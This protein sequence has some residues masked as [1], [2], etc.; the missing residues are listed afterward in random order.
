MENRMMDSYEQTLYKAV[1]S[2]TVELRALTDVL[3]SKGL[4]TPGEVQTAI[5]ES[6]LVDAVNH[7]VSEVEAP[8]HS[9]GN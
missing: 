5:S 9:A 7:A 1:V 3:S 8:A 4:I 6:G 2:N